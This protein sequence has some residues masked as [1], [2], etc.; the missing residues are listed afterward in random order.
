VAGTES[1]IPS[2][3]PADVDI[4]K[5]SIA[6][7]YDYLLGGYHNFEVDRVIAKKSL[8]IYPDLALASQ[9]NRA[10]LRRAVHYL[11][12]QGIS[13]FIDIGS[14]I[15]TVGHVHELARKQNPKNR[16]VY[17][18]IDP[19][20]IAHSKAILQDNP[21][22][23]AFLADAR[24]PDGIYRHIEEVGLLDFSKPVALLFISL[25]HFIHDENI[26][27]QLVE[28]Y[29]N[30]L[31]SGSR[32]VFTHGTYENIPSSITDG[33]MELSAKSSTPAKYRG[34]DDIASLFPNLEFVEPGIVY[35]PL[36]RPEGAEDIFLN[37]PERSLAY[38]GVAHLVYKC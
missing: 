6:R 13:Q 10:F 36:W 27:R 30:K 16:V 18:D 20:V 2:W 3:V 9:A 4:D 7:I 1:R 14:G 32:L 38:A 26:V 22:A 31:V 35:T 33:I 5:P 23:L 24:D 11:L 34:Y 25:F 12:E 29:F 28:T 17:V 19:V 15:P 37:Q 8:E 21:N